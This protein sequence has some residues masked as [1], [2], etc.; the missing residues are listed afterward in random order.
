MIKNKGSYKHLITLLLVLLISGCGG[1][2]V[3]QQLTMPIMPADPVEVY[4]AGFAFLGDNDQR[5]TR[6]PHAVAIESE[7]AKNGV[8]LIDDTLRDKIKGFTAPGFILNHGLGKT[9]KGDNALSIAIA[10]SYEDVYVLP[11]DG[12]FKVSYDIT[13]NVVVFD[14]SDKKV[15]AA[16]P[17]RFLHN[18]LY[19][20]RPTD[21]QHRQVVKSLL[22]TN[23]KGINV[24]DEIIKRMKGIVI[25][26]TPGNYIGVN[27]VTL[28]NKALK[29]IPSDL[30]E[31]ESLVAQIAQEFEGQLSKSAYVPMVPFTKGEAVGAKMAARFSNGDSYEFELPEKDYLINLEL[32]GFKKHSSADHDGF[33]SALGITVV[34]ASD[35]GPGK[36]F[37]DASFTHN[38][39]VVKGLAGENTVKNH[40]TIYESALSKLIEDLSRQIVSTDSKWLDMHAFGDDVGEQFD[41]F[42]GLLIKSR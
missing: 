10:L 31:K 15:I 9:N 7:T 25:N 32:R 16:Y 21:K 20:R 12:D 14:F 1:S 36:K 27:S 6:Y 23:D 29:Y 35:E 3:R 40:W 4:W 26:P 18:E 2:N 8:S 24:F 5:E 30:L 19:K 42:R 33:V 37:V 28:A 13:M 39:W 17:M 38:V 11:F 41:R 22:T 34:R